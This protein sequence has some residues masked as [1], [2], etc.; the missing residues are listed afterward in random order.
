MGRLKQKRGASDYDD[1]YVVSHDEALLQYKTAE[2]IVKSIRQF[3][4]HQK[5]YD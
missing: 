4:I 2:Q 1:F 5:I 3:L